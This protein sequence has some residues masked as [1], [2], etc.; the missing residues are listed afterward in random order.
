M[1]EVA[2]AIREGANAY[3]ARQFRAIILLVSS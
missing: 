3:L 1:Q 2:R